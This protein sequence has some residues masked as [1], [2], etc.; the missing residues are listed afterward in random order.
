LESE[1]VLN[2][3]YQTPAK[4]AAVGV[5]PVLTAEPLPGKPTA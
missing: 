3:T 2:P 1:T 5:R 4:Y